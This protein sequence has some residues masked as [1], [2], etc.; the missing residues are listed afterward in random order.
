LNNH[1]LSGIYPAMIT[2][3]TADNQV[4]TTVAE[5]LLARLCAA[6]V[7]GVYVAGSTGEGLLLSLHSRELLVECLMRN[8]P[9]GRKLLVQV[10]ANSVEDALHLAEHAAKA[11]AHA[12]SSLPPEGSFSEVRDYY[13]RLAA[14]SDLPLILYYFPQVRPNAFRNPEEL[15]EI[16][17]VPNVAAVKFT[18]YNLFLMKQLT[19]HG[20]LI[21]NGRDEILAAGLLMGAAGG[22]G[23]TYNLAPRLYVELYKHAIRGE[24]KEVR[25]L[26]EEVHKLVSVLIKYPLLPAIKEALRSTGLECGAALNGQRFNGEVELKQFLAELSE[27][28]PSFS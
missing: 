21:Y 20:T 12:I 15:E 14:H 25:H 16:C 2:P 3:L 4:S 11:G 17:M 13:K 24:W 22:I 7:D 18:D 26:Q 9:R 6:G 28:V 1:W 5:K 10:G 19:M 23:S 27:T 8:L